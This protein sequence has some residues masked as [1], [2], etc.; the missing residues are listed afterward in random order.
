MVSVRANA[1]RSAGRA[2]GVEVGPGGVEHRPLDVVRHQL[3]HD[4]RQLPQRLGHPGGRP[5]VATTVAV[6]RG[7]R[8]RALPGAAEAVA[9][10]VG[11]L[12]HGV[13]AQGAGRGHQRVG[14]AQ[15]VVERQPDAEQ[16]QHVADEAHVGLAE[17]VGAAHRVGPQ[18]PGRRQSPQDL[19]RHAAAL[20][21]VGQPQHRVVVDQPDRPG[22]AVVEGLGDHAQR[23]AALLELADAVEAVAMVGAVPGHPAL[24]A[25]R[26]QQALRL[27]GAQRLHADAGLGGQ[28]VGPVAGGR[29]GNRA[30]RR[31]RGDVRGHAARLL[32]GTFLCG[33]FLERFLESV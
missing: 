25:G 22:R 4:R 30:G 23:V 28:L 24:V 9:D 17:Q 10:Q 11:P 21:H 19:H 15:E 27:V 1:A 13:A 16:G 32:P 7:G 5:V 20:G 6:G 8:R 3:A 12:G 2:P 18:Q 33:A 14:D 31:G 26:G 29:G